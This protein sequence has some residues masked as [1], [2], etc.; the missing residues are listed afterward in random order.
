MTRKINTFSFFSSQSSSSTYTFYRTKNTYLMI[1]PEGRGFKATINGKIV[2]I[3]Y[4]DF[5][6]SREV[7]LIVE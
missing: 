3:L 7:E 6:G 5:F 1:N 2:K 4:S